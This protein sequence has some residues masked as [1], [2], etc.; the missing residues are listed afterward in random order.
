MQFQAAF[1]CLRYVQCYPRFLKGER[2]TNMIDKRLLGSWV[3]ATW[4]GWLLGIPIII[5]LALCGE[6]VHIGGAQFLVGTGM[7][8]GI[9][10]IQARVIRK[11]LDKSGSWILSCVVGLSVPF[12]V[13]DLSKLVGWHIGYSLL[14][15][16][17]IA[18]LIIG[19]WQTLILRTRFRRAGLWL[20]ASAIG[21][22]LAA[23]VSSMADTIPR[24]LAIRGILG[25][26]A[27]L[28]F[29]AVGGLILGLITGI[30][31]AMMKRREL[32]A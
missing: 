3:R 20:I 5:V 7:G 6:A 10:L 30:C 18:G 16:I 29:V 2:L 24:Q 23:G 21:W 14:V 1:V 25:A 9:G 27:Y 13:T 12:L 26:L 17:T 31:L 15:L 22:T 32:A 4:L 19:I 11:V 28:G 8:I